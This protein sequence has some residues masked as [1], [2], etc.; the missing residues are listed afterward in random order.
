[1]Q[2]TATLLR[3]ALV[4]CLGLGTGLATA[5]AD[6]YPS[7][8]IRLIVPYSA[9]GASDV[10]ARYYAQKLGEKLNQAVI[11]DNQAAAAGSIA[12]GI[13]ARAA[14]DGYTLTYG[15]SSL[16]LNAILRKNASFDP[17]RDFAPVS[18]LV[19]V[20]NLL[21]VPVS[22]SV[23]SVTEL[24]AL[25]KQKPGELNYVSLGRG[26]TPH[27]SMELF[28]AAA[29]IKMEPVVYKLTPQAYTDLIEARVQAW[30][31]SMP[32]AITFVRSGKLRALA[33]AGARRSPAAPDVPT[34]QE[35]GVP[36]ETIFWQGLFAPAGTPDDIVK[37]LNQVSN[38]IAASAE[39][40]AWFLN[41]G[42]ELE[43]GTPQQLGDEVR[44]ETDK[45]RVI[46]KQLDLQPE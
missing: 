1:M 6:T 45:W 43:G 35:A 25:A 14:P 31:A 30:L 39:A 41:L 28:A 24:V 8:S 16:A 9:G 18:P 26:S 33:V 10:M 32:S 40:K 34:L 4:L 44:R 36:A 19:K 2:T 42:A 11:V 17:V 23:Q 38:E 29:G 12:Y 20:Q 15:T 46:A 37:R 27:L 21:V 13:G 3:A 5:T 7:K 22:S